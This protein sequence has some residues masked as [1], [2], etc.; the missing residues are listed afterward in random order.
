MHG[1]SMSLKNAPETNKISII[2]M[3]RKM[4]KST[5]PKNTVAQDVS[6][7]SGNIFLARQRAHH[8]ENA[9]QKAGPERFR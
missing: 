8:I 1:F 6:R 2:V 3:A 5:K 4:T 9:L 7:A